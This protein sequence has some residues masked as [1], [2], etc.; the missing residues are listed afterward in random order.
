MLN[1]P[2][3]AQDAESKQ[4]KIPKNE[5]EFIK[6]YLKPKPSISFIKQP[7]KQR[8][9]DFIHE[10]YNQ[11]Y[12]GVKVDGGGFNFH[13]KKGRMYL[14]HGNYIDVGELS[15]EPTITQEGAKKA[16]ASYK[17]IPVDEV[18]GFKSEL[19]IKEIVISG[20]RD[21]SCVALVFKIYLI[22][23]HTNNDEIGFIDAHSGKVLHTQPSMTGVSATATFETRYNGSRQAT[24]QYYNDTYNLCDSSR[25]AVI[26][27]RDLNGSTNID[28]GVE[29]TDANN[30]WTSEEFASNEDDMALDIHWALQEIY[31]YLED[32]YDINSFDNPASGSGQD[33][34]AYFHYGEQDNAR[35]LMADTALVFGN[36][37][38]IC[39]PFASLDVV[40]HEYGHGITDFQI[41]WAYSGDLRIFHEGLSDIWGV[42]LENRIS[43]NN[44][45][46]IGEEIILNDDC[47][48]NI[49]DP[50]DPNAY[51]EMSDT[52][53]SSTYTGDQY[54]KSGVFSHWF[55]LLVN[56]GT[57]TNDNNNDYIVY[58]IGM[59]AAE[60][61][62]VASVF[63]DYLDNQTTYPGIR[64]QIVDAADEEFFGENSF[65]SLQVEAAWYAVGVGTEPTQPAISGPDVVC[66]SNST[67]TA[68]NPPAG[69]TI[70]WTTSSNLSVI[71][72]GTTTTP[73]IRAKY[74][75]SQGEGWIQ[76]N[77]TSNGYYTPGSRIDVWVGKPIL[78][79]DDYSFTNDIGEEGY[80]CTTHDNNN[81][82]VQTDG[83][84]IDRYEIKLTNLSETQ[85]YKQ[86]IT[87]TGTGS[88]DLPQLNEGFYLFWARADND[89]GWSDWCETEIEYMDCGQMMM[90]FTPNPTVEETTL[91]IVPETYENATLKS[92]STESTFDYD[93]EWEVEVYSAMQKLQFKKT[94]IKGT[95]KTLINTQS[96]KEGV[97]M[98]RVKY[99]DEVLSGKLVVNK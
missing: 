96:W 66:Y 55:Y 39:S 35:W 92:A 74:S 69:S 24:T 29:L 44:I 6:N 90:L 16:F 34:N 98:V 27:T 70:S 10:H 9:N 56:G 86:F 19:M 99:K 88:L 3:P 40:A 5:N 76:A 64:T 73:T 51:M 72:G 13:F 61:L 57:G 22:S 8:K 82:D 45:W 91:S 52:Y 77:Y 11:Y 65:Q 62:L 49:Q 14:A 21:T 60:E 78:N 36:G 17:G 54:V 38:T 47:I 7:K 46:V 94:K 32:E 81:F 48:R 25:N 68:T 30:I 4:I 53:L 71:S 59:D 23:G 20:N 93:A 1:S 87:T 85:T 37:N 33:I 12:N 63:N 15:T 89:C 83:Q 41:G 43:P 95:N 79:V 18:T 2:P 28:N 26:H 58:G 80:F 75:S 31:D 42:I 84:S 67:F 50:D 97:Y